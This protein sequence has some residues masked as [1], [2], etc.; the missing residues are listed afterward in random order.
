MKLFQKMSHLQARC[1]LCPR[2]CEISNYQ[3]GACH[4]RANS[5]GKIVPIDYGAISSLAVEPIEKKPFRHFMSGTKTLSLGGYGC[6]LHCRY[7]ENESISQ[8]GQSVLAKHFSVKNIVSDAKEKHCKSVCMTYNEPTLAIE[9]LLHLAEE[10]HQNDLK[11]I[12]KTNAYIN[13]EPWEEVCK[14]VD[15]MNIDFKGSFDRFEEITECRYVEF[16]EKIIVAQNNDVHV[17]FS[18]P[19][20]PDVETNNGEYFWPLELLTEVE[21]DIPCHLLKVNPAYLMINERATSDEE[22]ESARERLQWIFPTIY[23]S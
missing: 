6:N 16:N 15:A 12:I 3:E 7:C 4:A 2:Y 14:V 22:I 10:C 17:E 9:Y 18:I 1:L 21:N 11:F 13:Q 5:E 8:H 23:I 20:F 19:I